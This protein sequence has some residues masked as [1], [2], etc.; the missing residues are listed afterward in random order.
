MSETKVCGDCKQELPR[1][2][3]HI[4]WRKPNGTVVYRTYCKACNAKRAASWGKMNRE[5]VK[6]AVKK[7]K[8]RYR[9][10]FDKGIVET[11]VMLKCPRCGKIKSPDKFYAQRASL[12]GKQGYCI[13]CDLEVSGEWKAAHA[14]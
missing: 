2:E 9:E 13:P 8:A 3:F 14:H 11:P 4:S 10:Q 7:T 6:R 12:Y 5:A 1:S